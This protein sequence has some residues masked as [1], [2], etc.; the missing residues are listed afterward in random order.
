[1]NN[2][3]VEDR[4]AAGLVGAAFLLAL[5]IESGILPWAVLAGTGI[6]A[7]V[8][9]VRRAWREALFAGGATA[10]VVVFFGVLTTISPGWFTSLF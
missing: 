7:V 8:L 1:M 6:S 9:L 4:F 3:R 10:A 5:I 2:T